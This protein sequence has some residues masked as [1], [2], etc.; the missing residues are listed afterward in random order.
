MKH[1]SNS[2]RLNPARGFTLIELLVVIAIIAILAAMLLPALASA[3]QKALTAQCSNNMKQLLLAHHMYVNDNLDRMALANAAACDQDKPGWLYD[4]KYDGGSGYPQIVTKNFGPELGTWWA[5]LHSGGGTPSTAGTT[6][7]DSTKVS[8]WKIYWCP[9]DLPP[10]SSDP[11]YAA[12]VANGWVTFDSYLMNWAVENYGN[13]P[14]GSSPGTKDYSRKISDRGISAMSVLLWVPDYKLDVAPPG[15][16]WNDGAVQP[17]VTA[18]APGPTHGKG[19]PLGFM[20]GHV[21]FWSYQYQIYP[22]VTALGAPNN[23]RNDFYY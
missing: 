10:A 15:H 8:A 14:G 13:G 12:R 4:P 19:E 22:E 2:S 9:A 21:E 18:E 5:Y 3:K 20:D 17:N 23:V 6:T 16:D 1:R 11:S 7:T